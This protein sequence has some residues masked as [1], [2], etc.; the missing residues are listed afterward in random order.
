MKYPRYLLLLIIE[1]KLG[2]L[3]PD[4]KY[5]KIKYFLRVGK[6]LDLHNPKTF[7]EKIQWLKLYDRNPLYTKLVD[8][9]AVRDYVEKTIGMEYL[10]S[11]LGVY[12]NFSNIDFSS[13]PDQFVL[14]PNHTSGDV[15]ICKD[16]SKINFKELKRDVDQ[17][18]KKNYFWL[19][20]EWPYK[21]VIPNIICEKYMVDES[22]IELKDYKIHCFNGIPRL[23]Q[24]DFGRFSNHRR[25]LYT[26]DWNYI[27]ASI[28]YPN[29]PNT[30]IEKPENLDQLLDI[31]KNLSNPFPY[32]RVDLYLVKAKIYFGELT[33]HHGAGYEKFTPHELEN[34][35]GEWIK[36][37][38]K[39]LREKYGK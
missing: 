31:A 1:T 34:K 35:M 27:E 2:R 15:F 33:F 38:I 32:V 7:N 3:F 13:L 26:S 25:N 5:L 39:D 6:K 18:L 4:E 9:Y 19:H 11:L 20:R 21:N 24:V 22:N 28:L 14:K 8:K 10:I 23:I 36:L 29:D 16:K 12:N 30:I 17:W 37:P